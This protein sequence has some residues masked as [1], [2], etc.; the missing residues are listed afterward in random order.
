[1]TYLQLQKARDY[2][3]F[4]ELRLLHLTDILVQNWAG[5][6]FLLL[7]GGQFSTSFLSYA[8]PN[9]RAF[10]ASFLCIAKLPCLLCKF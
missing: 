1:M 9:C 2:V 7:R 10:C 4:T 6:M 8:L 3:S 5:N